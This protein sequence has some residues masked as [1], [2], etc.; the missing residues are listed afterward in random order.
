MTG[1]GFAVPEIENAP[2]PVRPQGPRIPINPSPPRR[3]QQPPVR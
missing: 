3:P 1:S 2:R